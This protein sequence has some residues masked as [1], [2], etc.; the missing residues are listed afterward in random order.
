M[1]FVIVFLKK[2][3]KNG[4]MRSILL[5]LLSLVIPV[6]GIASVPDSARTKLKAACTVSLN[7][8]GISTI[9]AFSLGGPAIMSF[10]NLSKGRFSYDPVLAYGLDIKPWF[11]DNW[12]HYHIID[13]DAFKLRT[14]INF[15]VFFSDVKIPEEEIL[16][17][18]RYWAL[19]L[20]G[21]YNLTSRTVLSLMYWNDRGQDP[22]TLIGHFFSLSGE[23]NEMRIGKSLLLSA[24]LQIFYIDYDGNN[25]GLFVAPKISASVKS[26]PLALFFQATQPLVTN[27]SP[28][29]GFEWNLG[30]SYSF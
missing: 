15:S 13:R 14:G 21:I 27:I 19:E 2:L 12:L 16:K 30:I 1:K 9:P 4:G 20:A 18:E 25:D 23:H 10:I 6:E 24:A 22:G 26:I 7:T 3:I 5:L 28:Y 8:N 29:P 11:I 17:G